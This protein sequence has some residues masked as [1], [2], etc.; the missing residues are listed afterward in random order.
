MCRSLLGS[1]KKKAQQAGTGVTSGKWRHHWPAHG[2]DIDRAPSSGGIDRLRGP[3][4]GEERLR[5]LAARAQLCRVKGDGT[6]PSTGHNRKW[7]DCT[8]QLVEASGSYP[9]V[10]QWDHL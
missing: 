8:M 1:K 4:G 10:Q 2:Q 6:A 5:E 7:H 9:L 3:G